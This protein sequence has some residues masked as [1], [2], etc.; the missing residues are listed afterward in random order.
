MSVVSTRKMDESE[1]QLNLARAVMSLAIKSSLDGKTNP[2]ELA[3]V[4]N[5]LLH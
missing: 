5:G 2:T 4:V 3:S 1:L